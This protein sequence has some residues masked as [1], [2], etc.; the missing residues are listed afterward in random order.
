MLYEAIDVPSSDS[1]YLVLEYMKGGTLMTIKL[2]EGP[3]EPLD[4]ETARSYLRQLV[5][6]LEYLHENDVAHR[7][8][9]NSE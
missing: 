6:G 4:P 2:G 8:V 7:D 1:L 3:A 9:S 5:L